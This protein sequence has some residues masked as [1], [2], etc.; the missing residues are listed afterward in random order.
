[1][2]LESELGVGSVSANK[3]SWVAEAVRSIPSMFV[4]VQAVRQ[5][6][7]L[8]LWVRSGKN[9][10]VEFLPCSSSERVCHEGQKAEWFFMYACVLSK[11]HPNGWGFIRAF[12]ILMEYLQ[13]DPSL[14]LFFYLFQA[15]GV[16]RGIWVALSSHQGRTIFSLFK[17]SYRDFKGGKVLTT[18]ELLK[19]ESNRGMVI[20]YL[21]TKVPECS[22][23]G[24]KSFSKQRAEREVSTSLV[25][26]AEQG[27]EVN[28]PSENRKPI[29]MKRM[30]GEE[31]SGKKVI[32]LTEKR[33]CDKEFSRS[34]KDLHGFE[35]TED[36]SSVWC[37]HLPFTV[38]ADEHFESKADLDLLGKVGK[39]VV[40]RYMQVQDARF[41]CITR[42]LEVQALEE[43]AFQKKKVDSL[44]KNTKLE[45][46]LKMAVEQV[47]LK[48][49]EILLLNDENE[50][51]RNKVAKVS[52][53][54]Q[55]LKDR[56]VELC[57]KKKETEESK[58]QHGF[59]MFVVA[60]ESAKAQAELFA[61]GV[62][63]EEIDHLKVVYKGGLIDDDQV[64]SE[65]S[66]DHNPAK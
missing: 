11:I 45:K 44:Q 36:L 55:D 14:E 33:C 61:P 54:K 1:M 24:L 66:D 34:Q 7:D 22:T 48:G 65:G 42:E 28:K 21:E 6:G 8:S 37:E 18:S 43:E 58:K 56:V 35:D 5:L 47:D 26:K 38:V 20:K 51:L 19:W 57:G 31:A 27:S 13:E 62:K 46:K 41:M 52:K 53:D 60:W 59:E 15:K 40:A 63:F 9:V 25:I 64:P 50:D 3:Y 10:A 2:A 30:R 49:K 17:A 39:V 16:D 23:A 4:D 12:E 29:S 32:D